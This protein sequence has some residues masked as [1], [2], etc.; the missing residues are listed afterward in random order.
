MLDDFRAKRPKFWW[1]V[2]S[3]LTHILDHKNLTKAQKVLFELDS[4]AYLFLMGAL[5]FELFYKVNH[6][7]TTHELWESIKHT[8]G[9]S[10]T[11]DDG[12]VKKEGEPKEDTHED[13]EHDHNLVIVKDCST[14]WSS[15][16]DDDRSTT[17]SLDKVDDDA[18]SVATD[19]DT[20]C[21]L[22]GDDDGSCFGYESDAST[23]SPTSPHCFMSHGDARYLL[24]VRLLIVMI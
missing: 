19:D 11:W 24:V 9:D 23:S 18:T 13:V 16:D 10:S 1:V 22:D 8:F 4:D 3:G 5:S 12:K 6:K 7:G 14:S 17:R 2:I 15:D 20:P 21:T